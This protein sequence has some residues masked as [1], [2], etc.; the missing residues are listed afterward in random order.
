MPPKA[1]KALKALK[2]RKE[3]SEAQRAQVVTLR[4]EGYSFLKIS[5]HTGVPK[6]TCY[7]IG[8][9]DQERRKLGSATPY[10]SSALRSGR[11]EKITCRE[12]RHLIQLAKKNRRAALG[13]LTCSITIKVSM[14]TARKVLKWAGIQKRHAK[15]KPYLSPLHRLKH[16][17]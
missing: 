14:N 8:K 15:R 10:T 6:S 1:S 2:E 5:E 16:M 4:E 11:P 12:C 17:L 7:K 3:T 9:R 13:I